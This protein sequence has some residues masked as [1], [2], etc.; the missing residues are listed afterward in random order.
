[1]TDGAR[2]R[3]TVRLFTPG[4]TAIPDAV[5]AAEAAPLLPARAPAFAARMARVSE[6]LRGA[7]LTRGD[8]VTLT[9]SGT[10]A[11]EAAFV[12]LVRR[13]DRVLVAHAGKFGERWLAIARAHG[14]GHRA[15]E[16][17]WGRPV[18]PADLARALA[19]GPAPAAVLLT[20]SETST[21]VVHD[22]AALTRTVRAAG[23]AL[24]VVDAVSSAGALPLRMDEWGIDA[25][26]AAAHKGFLCPPGLAF[27]AL[28][29]RA[30]ARLAAADLPRY[31]F[32]LRP[33]LAGLADGGTPWTP[34]VS[35][36]NALAAAL[37]RLLAGGLDKAWAR[38]AALA[39]ATRA[40]VEAGGL[41]LFA[42]PPGDAVTA[43]RAPA[44]VDA[45]RVVAGLRARGFEIAGGQDAIKR[46]VFRIASLG[47][48]QDTDLLDLMDALE[49]VLGELD[50]PVT[51]PGAL[52]AAAA[53][54][55]QARQTT[56]APG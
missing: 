13:S 49:A 20:H 22:V 15:L 53:G 8:V 25:C 39:A 35:L 19:A 52:R 30:K 6:L 31:Y 36:V 16:A 32:D 42:T 51:E 47:D 44:G 5:R 18:A 48:I 4:P 37:E 40:G 24:V 34:A 3:S 55:L 43:V 14:I 28:G 54:A 9:A 7:F 17:P 10:G 45:R 46:S 29:D 23:D 38:T 1:M 41:D 12:N 11:L 33:A 50:A 27:V 2:G 56:R 21:G 26:V